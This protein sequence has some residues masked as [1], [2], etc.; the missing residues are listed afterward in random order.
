MTVRQL[1]IFVENRPGRLSAVTG[2]LAEAG[3]NIRALSIA[4]T[5]DF[6]IMRMLVDDTD[7]ALTTLKNNG[8]VASVTNVIAVLGDDK[9]GS[10]ASIVKVL[11]ED[12]ISVE[13][14]YAGF[15]NAAKETACLVLRVDNN[16]SAVRALSEAGIKL[17][18]END[19][20]QI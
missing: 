9:P 12:N 20:A 18:S 1:S 14:M 2:T 10:L 6:G 16:E 8:F 13:Y 4:D 3:I 5:N 11:Y 7:C 17:L 15:I 19:I